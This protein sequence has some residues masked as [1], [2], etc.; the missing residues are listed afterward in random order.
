MTKGQT[1]NNEDFDERLKDI[2]DRTKKFLEYKQDFDLGVAGFRAK[3]LI[4]DL[5]NVPQSFGVQKQQAQLRKI[6]QHVLSNLISEV[7]LW[8]GIRDSI[9][10]TEPVMDTLVDHLQDMEMELERV[11]AELDRQ[12]HF[13]GAMSIRHKLQRIDN[14]LNGITP[15]TDEDRAELDKAQ[16]R[17]KAIARR[18]LVEVFEINPNEEP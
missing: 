2:Q 15:A 7:T 14:E 5:E 3:R 8:S 11:I 17:L 1:V 6:V 12:A 18:L 16:D 13:G 4:H 9:P 10:R